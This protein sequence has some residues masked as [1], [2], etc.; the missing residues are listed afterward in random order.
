MHLNV[1]RWFIPATACPA[2]ADY[3]RE[4]LA[5]LAEV[6]TVRVGRSS[7]SSLQEIT[8]DGPAFRIVTKDG[9]AWVIVAPYA[10]L[11]PPLHEAAGRLMSVVSVCTSSIRPKIEHHD[12]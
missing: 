3:I 5:R 8:V 4:F 2:A 11:N 10:P 1:K 9:D 6:G 12:F 7:D